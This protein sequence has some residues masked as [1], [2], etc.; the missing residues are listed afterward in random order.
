ML[1]HRR[2]GLLEPFEPPE[3]TIDAAID[4][5]W[6]LHGRLLEPK[7]EEY[8]QTT[9]GTPMFMDRLGYWWL[10]TPDRRWDSGWWG[11]GAAYAD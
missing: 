8:L 9:P 2:S 4:R 1:I 11:D 7:A 6:E 5:G 3:L 10:G